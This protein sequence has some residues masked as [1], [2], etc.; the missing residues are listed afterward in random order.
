MT[1]LLTPDFPCDT[2]MGLSHKNTGSEWLCE[3]PREKLIP[4][5]PRLLYCVAMQQRSRYFSLAYTCCVRHTQKFSPANQSHHCCREI[6]CYENV[7]E[8][9]SHLWESEIF[10]IKLLPLPPSAVK[11][12]M[13]LFCISSTIF[14]HS[15][16]LTLFSW[17]EL[18]PW[19]L[20]PNLQSQ[21]LHIFVVQS[22]LLFL[23]SNS[24]D[25]KVFKGYACWTFRTLA[26]QDYGKSP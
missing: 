19:K 17:H 8:A 10:S 9:C 14:S 25:A 11:C 18:A 13:L 23:H 22:G 26:F 1:H 20:T 6:H 24:N 12:T 16:R 2:S 15:L 3:Y 4:I 7:M 5:L 21:I